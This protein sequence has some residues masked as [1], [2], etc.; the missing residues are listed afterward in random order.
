MTNNAKSRT[1]TRL[2]AGLG[3]FCLVFGVLGYL[4]AVGGLS[5]VPDPS[6]D[7]RAAAGWLARYAPVWLILWLVGAAACGG[8][9][10]RRAG[11][12][13]ASGGG[14]EEGHGAAPE[15]M[16]PQCGAPLS[17]RR[18]RE[19]PRRGQPYW[20]CREHGEVS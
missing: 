8:V 1:R 16:C 3:L 7:P 17:L 9:A 12:R 15:R 6:A 19:G 10:W 20:V 4:Y 2:L 14:Q 11:S 13:H 5:T 18:R